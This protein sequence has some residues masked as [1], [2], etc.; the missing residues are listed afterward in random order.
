MMNII[1]PYFNELHGL[2]NHARMGLI[3]IDSLISSKQ[4]VLD[5]QVK[6]QIIKLAYSITTGYNRK[7]SL[8]DKIKF[9]CP[10][11]EVNGALTINNSLSCSTSSM[12]FSFLLGFFLGDGNIYVRIRDGE[13]GL[14]FIPR[15]K[16]TQVINEAN[17]TLFLNMQMFLKS[18]G[19][20]S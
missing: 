8:I 17:Y 4:K 15:F 12:N 20:N 2:K 7:Y 5:D 6:I 19:I 16:L 9:I 3:E 14:Q 18:A 11:F 10:N 13:T 1:L